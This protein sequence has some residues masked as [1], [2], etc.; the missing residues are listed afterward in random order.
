LERF[1]REQITRRERSLLD[2][3]FARYETELQARIAGRRVL[4]V[5]GG[6]SIGSHYIK[7]LLPFEIASLCV[8]DISEN[9]L[10]ELVR[11]L[12][13]AGAYRIPEQFVTYPVSYAT[14]LFGRILR[15]HGPFDIV[16]NFAAHKHVRSEKDVLSIHA[17][18]ENNVF[19][20]R[21]LL[22]RLTDQP[23]EHV[24]F[25]STD[26]AVDPVNVMGATK[27]L[28]EELVLAYAGQLPV[29]TARFA[30][31]A[32]SNGSLLSG[33]LERLSKRQPWACPIGIRRYFVSPAE[34]GQL[35]LMASIMG[36]TGGIVFPKLDARR[37]LVSFD[38]VALALLHA[39]DME[40]DVCRSEG[41]A[42]SKME[43]V[44]RQL[45]EGRTGDRPAI[46]WPV[47]F[48]ESDTSGEKTFEEFYTREEQ[49]D[50]GMFVN[51]GVVRPVKLRSIAEIESTIEALG[52]LFRSE[53][54]SKAAVVEV[55]KQSLPNF[56]HRETGRNLDQK[57]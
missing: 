23:P 31:V 33:F 56:Q 39:L 44:R 38:Q 9:G 10:T 35:C 49:P 4:V 14:P 37:D 27:K 22:E 51:L 34:S 53:N 25:V 54:P 40:A 7:A 50:F 26:K 43:V 28:M 29:K 20:A 12:R 41:E 21:E 15:A 1:I 30:N 3:D 5:G 36:P 32:F 18:V 8:V 16:A 47:H 6:G 57:M 48:F 42:R 52:A 13:S 45:E 55:L 2:A 11:D 19:R 46:R 17:M 24:F